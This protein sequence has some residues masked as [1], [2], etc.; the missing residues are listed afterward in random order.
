MYDA[1]RVN[2]KEARQNT[3]KEFLSFSYFFCSYV[4]ATIK[5]SKHAILSKR[6]SY[7]GKI[8]LK[9]FKENDK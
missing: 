2:K 7:L 8:K 3:L 6:D 1:D 5:K 4:V 9:S